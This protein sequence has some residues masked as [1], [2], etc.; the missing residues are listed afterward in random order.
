MKILIGVLS[1]I[2]LLM[3]MMT[4]QSCSSKAG[5]NGGDVVTLNNGLAKAEVVANADTGE[6]MVHTW[7]Q[8]LKHSQPIDNK[9]LI[10]ARSSPIP[11]RTPVK[12]FIFEFPFT[13]ARVLFA[14][15]VTLAQ[16]S[17]LGREIEKVRGSDP[18]IS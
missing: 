17:T 1:G 6:M 4:L 2:G 10:I 7:D 14:A 12:I 9:P 16:L 3:A 8:N 15:G 18:R 11:L 5:P 13:F